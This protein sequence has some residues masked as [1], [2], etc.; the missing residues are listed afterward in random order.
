MTDKKNFE[1]GERVDLTQPM[2]YPGTP[3]GSKPPTKGAEWASSFQG[4]ETP[5]APVQGAGP[6]PGPQGPQ[7]TQAPSHSKEVTVPADL[8]PMPRPLPPTRE[9]TS[10]VQRFRETFGISRVAGAQASLKVK[11]PNNPGEEVTWNFRFRGLQHEDLQWALAKSDEILS[12][13]KYAVSSWKTAVICVGISGISMGDDPHVPLYEMMGIDPESLDDVKDPWFPSTSLRH[14]SAEAF[15]SLVL[16]SLF[17]LVVEVYNLYTKEVDD[18]YRI[19]G[20]KEDP[21]P[22]KEESSPFPLPDSAS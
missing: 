3:S 21:A 19:R 2:P 8:P 5:F 18:S 20:G 14:A 22:T 11:D 1:L 6:G 15:S 10:L 13:G 7:A 16:S 12:D 9:E 17:D 4:A